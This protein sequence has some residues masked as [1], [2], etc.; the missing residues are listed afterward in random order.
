MKTF[1]SLQRLCLFKDQLTLFTSGSPC[2]AE[3]GRSG[4]RNLH[5]HMPKNPASTTPSTRLCQPDKTLFYLS[6]CEFLTHLSPA[7][8]KA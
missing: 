8:L 1:G 7:L 4:T 2:A 3:G 6:A 5:Y